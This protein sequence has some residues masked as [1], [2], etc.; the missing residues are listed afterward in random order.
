MSLNLDSVELD[1][2][3]KALP[4]GCQVVSDSLRGHLRDTGHLFH[5]GGSSRRSSQEEEGEIFG[6]RSASLRVVGGG[7]L[8][9]MGTHCRENKNSFFQLS[10]T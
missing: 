8:R 4:G 9:G 1:R 5:V 3:D 6:V 10:K 7:A 2:W